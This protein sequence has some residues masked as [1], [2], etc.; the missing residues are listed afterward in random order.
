MKLDSENTGVYNYGEV[1]RAGAR[2]RETAI[3]GQWKDLEYLVG[4]MVSQ[5]EIWD[6]YAT[7]R[8][9]GK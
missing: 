6:R 7:Q 8:I 9:V 1:N 5:N 2:K 3:L 4:R